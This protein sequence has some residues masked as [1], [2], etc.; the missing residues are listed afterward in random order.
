MSQPVEN[1]FHTIRGYQLKQQNEN[2][3]TPA[4]EDY[5]EM[6]YR[7]CIEESHTRI[8]KLS[9]RLH[10]RPPSASKMVSR[11]IALGYLENDSTDRI[12]LTDHGKVTGAYLLERHNIV[13]RFFILIGSPNPLKE[14]EMV[15]H[16]LSFTTVL[17][18]QAMLEFFIKNPEAVRRFEAVRN[19]VPFSETSFTEN[20]AGKI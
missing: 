14:T 17:K 19:R 16:M 18:I 11:L 1:E 10:V 4:L 12:L 7:L 15:E 13:E 8:N 5:L 20:P 3:L 2:T 9:E 6:T